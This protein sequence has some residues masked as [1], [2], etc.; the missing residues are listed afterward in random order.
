MQSNQNIK[1]EHMKSKESKETIS[2]SKE[3]RKELIA[4]RDM[5]AR[6]PEFYKELI[7]SLD[8][9]IIQSNNL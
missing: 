8:R 6:S 9:I 7:A 1:K 5:Y 4:M 2:F 3:N